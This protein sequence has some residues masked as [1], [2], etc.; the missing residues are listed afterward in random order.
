[1]A[2]ILF[3]TWDGGG[4]V[5]PAIGIA[6]E[7]ARRG[8]SIT[9][10][11]HAQQR[12]VLEKAGFSFE[13]YKAAKSWSS[14]EPIKGLSAALKVFGLFTDRG[15]GVDLLRL[16]R[17]QTIDLLVID[18]MSLGAI[19]AAQRAGL[20]FVVLAHTFYRFLTHQWN[21]G[22]VGLVSRCKGMSPTKLWSSAEL[23]LVPTDRQ[24]DPAKESDIS[25]NVRY[26]GVV[27]TPPRLTE[28]EESGGEPV[29]LVSLSTLYVPGQDEA[30]QRILDALT[31]LPLKAIVTTGDAID[32]KSLRVPAN[33]EIHQRIPH[34]EI[35][36]KARC[37]IT[38]G[39]HSTTMRA[40]A[41]NLP[42]LIIPMHPMIDQQ[43]VA[44]SVVQHGA[45][46]TLRKTASAEE[47]RSAVKELV[48]DGQHRKAAAAIG[49]RLR[50]MNGAE[51]SADEI[52]ALLD[53]T[54]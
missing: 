29:V 11:G 9:F 46:I 16:V 27:Q 32:P 26:T 20:R 3:V 15:P 35:L 13:D 53:R 38:H 47:I 21:R 1:M 31:G 52:C 43:M 19:E 34:E 37:V 49:S 14:V 22:P 6:T 28:W 36:P 50:S 30:L 51:K 44:R 5:P 4:N 40:L 24:L 42:L 25:A 54:R 48:T 10:L 8:H 17:G 45:G 23:F 39:G 41:H 12:K 2:Q 33:A 18:V 7:L